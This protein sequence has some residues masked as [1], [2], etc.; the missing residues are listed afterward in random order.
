MKFSQVNEES[1]FPPGQFNEGDPV[2]LRRPG[3]SAGSFENPKGRMLVARVLYHQ[4]FAA[5]TY[6]LVGEEG[7]AAVGPFKDADLRRARPA[8]VKK[9]DSSRAF[10]I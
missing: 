8:R 9:R 10:A 2:R 3:A 1:K 7:G 4:L 5:P 6:A